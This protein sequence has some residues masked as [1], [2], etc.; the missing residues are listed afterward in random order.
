[1]AIAPDKVA[2]LPGQTA[3]FANYTS[4]VKGLNGLMI[5]LRGTRADISIDDFRLTMGPD[6]DILNWPLA[7]APTGFAFEE[8]VGDDS[9][10]ITMIWD[11]GDITNNW[12]RVEMLANDVTGLTQENVFF[13]GNVIGEIG[14]STTDARVNL[15]DV[16]AI[17]AN[18]SGFTS[19]TIDDFFDIDRDGR[20]N[21]IDVALARAN[22]SG[23][24]AL[25]LITPGSSSK[26]GSSSDNGRQGDTSVKKGLISPS[27]MLKSNVAPATS[28]KSIRL[29]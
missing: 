3:S 20:V 2:L 13:F 4:N 17:R 15:L 8:G 9:D 5:E 25:Q 7:P 22:Q 19:A 23:F 18:Q 29:K 28:I 27:I 21:L 6:N 1:M 12:L 10:R 11:A 24:T 14:N 26:F 16:A